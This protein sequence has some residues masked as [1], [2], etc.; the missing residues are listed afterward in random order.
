MDWNDLQFFLAVA[1]K[2]NIRKAAEWLKVNHSTV[3]RRI[4]AFEDQVGIRLF[5]RESSG[6]RL[7]PAGIDML[8][9]V[10]RIESEVLTLDR[11]VLGKNVQLHGDLRV[12]M[13]EPFAIYLMAPILTA[14]SQIYPEIQ[15]DLTISNKNLSLTRREADVALRITKQP[16]EHLVGR[17]IINYK[18]SVYASLE[19]LKKFRNNPE[20]MK[21]LGWSNSQSMPWWI[22]ESDF[23]DNLVRHNIDN[24]NLQ[25]EMTKAGAGIT[26]LP[27]FMADRV[28]Q[29]RRVPPGRL[30]PSHNIW[31]LTHRDLRHTTR[32]NVFMQFVYKELEQHKTLLLGEQP[33]ED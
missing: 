24:E 28:P 25:L 1:K 2:G 33:W 11:E 12:T 18:K 32:V 22:K 4:N 31:L 21:W 20:S 29:L 9:S 10:E 8:A 30:L 7:T 14:F 19:Y 23:K 5:N 26:M 17:K 16:P 6:Y 3:S 13:P 27:C 15:L